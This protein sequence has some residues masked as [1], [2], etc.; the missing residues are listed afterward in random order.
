[1]TE[2]LD[3]PVYLHVLLNHFPV[4]GLTMAIAVLVVGVVFRQTA[5]LFVGLV[6][7][8]LTAGSSLP[9]GILGDDAYPTVF[10]RLDGDGRAWLDYHTHLADTW[11]P[12]LYANAALAVIAL[13]VGIL[14]R[15]LLLPAALL[16]TL[17]TLAGI[18]TAVRIADAGGK[19]MHPEF[20]LIDPPVVESSRR[21]R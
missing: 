15:P 2:L 11:L 13:G 5:M 6:L 19:V 1:M 20:R 9:V 7:V 21:L 18:G 12:V 14:R 3:D 4:I 8:A 17:V 10:D 16:V